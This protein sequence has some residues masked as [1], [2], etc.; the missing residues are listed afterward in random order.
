MA[1]VR[2]CCHP[3]C[4]RPSSTP[5]NAAGWS[6]DFYQVN[7]D[8]SIDLKDFAQKAGAYRAVYFIN[9]FGFL[10]PPEVRIYLKGL[11]KNGVLVIEDN[12]Q[13]GFTDHPVGDFVFNSLRKLV[14]YDGGYLDTDL[15][16]AAYLHKYQGRPNRRLTLI[17]DYRQ[18][19]YDY[20]IDGVGSYKKLVE[21]Y[22]RADRYY[23]S[24]ITV[25]GDPGEQAQ[26]ERLDWKGIRKKRR[27]NYRYLLDLIAYIPEVQPIFPALQPANMPLGLPIYLNGVSRDAVYEHLGENSIGLFIHWEE[28][29]H[30]ARTNGNTLAVSMAG[31]MLTL[32]ID[33]RTSQAQMDYLA[34]TLAGGI[35]KVKR[36]K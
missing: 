8:L 25:D 26:I 15:D 2:S 13:A 22:S 27:E 9:Y 20:L 18:R 10:H 33:Q 1:S 12:A 32:A 21:L 11:Q 19:L 24:D 14:P 5:W 28:L 23:E 31:R 6:Y 35:Q 3:T 29:R 36:N 16:I 4:A 7:E 17:R 30:D 34:E